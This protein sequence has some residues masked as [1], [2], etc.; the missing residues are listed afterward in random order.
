MRFY[1]R[2]VFNFFWLLLFLA[3][4]A[5]AQETNQ[6]PVVRFLEATPFADE[7]TTLSYVLFDADDD[8]EGKLA[9]ELYYYPDDRLKS[10]EDVRTFSTMIA[11]E[12]DITLDIGTGDF[13]ESGSVEDV[14]TYTWDDP[15]PGLQNHGFAPTTKIFAGNY[16]L[17]L[18][19]DDGVN[20]PVFAVSDFVVTVDHE[21]ATAVSLTNWGQVKR[22]VR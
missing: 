1:L 11:S 12:K 22:E 8:A 4:C 17:Y 13:A 16:Y 5:R 10:V 21:A 20:E 7:S 6:P 2:T 18:V 15:G 19:A 3:L 9:Y 14:Q